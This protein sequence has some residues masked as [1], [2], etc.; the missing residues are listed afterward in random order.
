M[1]EVI[2]EWA[3]GY[4]YFLQILP[5][6]SWRGWVASPFA[7]LHSLVPLSSCYSEL[8][9]GQAQ[10]VPNDFSK[11]KSQAGLPQVFPIKAEIT[12]H[13]EIEKL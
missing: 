9:D 1:I 2:P 3:S 7:L 13:E 12:L 8:G 11:S 4:P 6:K 5:S 10:L